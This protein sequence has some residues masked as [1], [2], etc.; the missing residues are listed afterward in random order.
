MAVQH[1]PHVYFVGNQP[2]FETSLLQD[3]PEQSPCRL[4]LVPRFDATGTVVLVNLRTLDVRTIDIQ[5]LV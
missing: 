5:G 2:T 1:R 4:V 3:D